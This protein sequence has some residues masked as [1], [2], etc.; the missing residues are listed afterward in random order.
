MGFGDKDLI[1]LMDEF[2]EG[3]AAITPDGCKATV[4]PPFTTC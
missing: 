1:M 4:V 2:A 3:L